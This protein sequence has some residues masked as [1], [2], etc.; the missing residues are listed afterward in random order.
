MYVLRNNKISD[1]RY[2]YNP[3]KISDFLFNLSRGFNIG[4]LRS[5]LEKNFKFRIMKENG[6]SNVRLPKRLV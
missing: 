6:I 5:D 2:I 4:S 1:F 3:S